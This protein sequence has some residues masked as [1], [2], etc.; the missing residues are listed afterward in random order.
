[1]VVAAIASTAVTTMAAAV[2]VAVPSAPD[3]VAA[4]PVVSLTA[5]P[6]GWNSWNRFGCNID[7][8]LIRATAD[9]IVANNLDDLGYRYVNIDD[10]WMATTRDAR[11]RLQAHPTRFPSGIRA[12]ADYVH[13]RGLKLGIYESAGT[14]TCQGLPGSLE[15]ES[16]DAQTFANWQVDY[17]KY[18]NCNNQG[19]PAVQRYQAMGDALRAT[20]RPI[21]YSICNGI[22]SDHAD[23]GNATTTC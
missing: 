10:C 21:V 15:N 22:N 13:A 5:P 1:V 11:G 8:N 2:L 6:M 4:A 19:R 23:W 9:A 14:A 20:G 3:P 7:E 18:D 16:V 17:L 12:L